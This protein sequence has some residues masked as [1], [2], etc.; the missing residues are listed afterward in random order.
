M[1]VVVFLNG[2]KKYIPVVE[3]WIYDVDEESLKNNGANSNRNVRIFF[4]T[5][6]INNDGMP[7]AKY[8][9]KFH[10]PISTVYPPQ[11]EACFIGRIKSYFGKKKK[12]LEIFLRIL[13]IFDSCVMHLF[14][15]QET[16]TFHVML[17]Y[18]Q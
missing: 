18:S 1:F 13:D 10:L 5:I 2:I 12:S 9:P 17:K 16:I 4:S 3:Q 7:D 8:K 15:F 11:V 14:S 6:G